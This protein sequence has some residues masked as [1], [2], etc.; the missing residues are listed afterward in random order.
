MEQDDDSATEAGTT[1][2]P[3]DQ[4]RY[5][6]V[7]GVPL[8]TGT[9]VICDSC[10]QHIAAHPSRHRRLSEHVHLRVTRRFDGVWVASWVTCDDCGHVAD[11]EYAAP[12]EAY[13]VGLVRYRQSA[14]DGAGSFVLTK[15]REEPDVQHDG[16]RPDLCPADR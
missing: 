4:P 10:N 14:R 3:D 12:D 15:A 6:G 9:S 16:Q 11:D 13:V 8:G 7:T 5:D 1:E 2:L